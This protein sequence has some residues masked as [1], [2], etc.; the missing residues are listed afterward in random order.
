MG[1]GHDSGFSK[2][3]NAPVKLDRTPRWAVGVIAVLFAVG[4][5]GDPILSRVFPPPIPGMVEPAEV[6]EEVQAVRS[7]IRSNAHELIR[8]GP[9]IEHLHIEQD[10]QSSQISENQKRLDEIGEIVTQMSVTVRH[11]AEDVRDMKNGG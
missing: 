5:V 6:L 11:I 1:N 8:R 4:T 9:I 7:E 10:K 2:A 3:I